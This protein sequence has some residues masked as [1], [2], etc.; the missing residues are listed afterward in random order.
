MESQ[1]EQKTYFRLP[2][3]E[4]ESRKLQFGCLKGLGLKD[5]RMLGRKP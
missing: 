3:G 2:L 4:L 5:L 1:R